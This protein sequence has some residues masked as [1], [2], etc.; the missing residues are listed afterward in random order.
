MA[1]NVMPN[2]EKM[3]SGGSI[4]AQIIA[5]LAFVQ[6]LASAPLRLYDITILCADSTYWAFVGPYNP[7][8]ATFKAHAYNLRPDCTIKFKKMEMNSLGCIAEDGTN[9]VELNIIGRYE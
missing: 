2:P 4:S 7:D 5:P 9:T 8:P 3:W 1:V 6:P